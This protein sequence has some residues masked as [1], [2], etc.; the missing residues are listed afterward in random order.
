ML[1]NSSYDIATACCG[2]PAGKGPTASCKHIGALCNTLVSFCRLKTL[3][4]FVTHTEKLQEWNHSRPRKAEA[5]PV[6]ELST[7]RNEIKKKECS[8]SFKDYNSQPPSLKVDQPQLAENM[9]IALLEK[10][11]AFSQLLI[12]PS[13]HYI[14]RSYILY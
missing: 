10:K 13:K 7:R 6:I 1:H 3:P 5:I 12:A 2:C 11:S 4:D 14:K 9:H 8:F